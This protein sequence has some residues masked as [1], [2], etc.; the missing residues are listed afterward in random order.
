[1]AVPGRVIVYGGKGALGTTIVNFF[2]SKSW[3]CIILQEIRVASRV[4]EFLLSSIS[5]LRRVARPLVL[6]ISVLKLMGSVF[7]GECQCK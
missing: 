7:V 5:L 4:S 2:R 1:M 6:R 3:V